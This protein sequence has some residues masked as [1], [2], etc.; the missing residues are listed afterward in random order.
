MS[1]SPFSIFNRGG[2]L[3]DLIYR[4]NAEKLRRF[5]FRLFGRFRRG[6]FGGAL[7][8]GRERNPLVENVDQVLFAD[9]RV[10]VQPCAPF[11]GINNKLNL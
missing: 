9:F 8:L 1:G 2:F 3:L 5:R 6:I 10:A 7:H 4:K 11:A